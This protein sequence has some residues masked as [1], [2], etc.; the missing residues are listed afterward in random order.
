MNFWEHNVDLKS[1]NT[2]NL[3]AYAKDFFTIS[4]QDDFFRFYDVYKRKENN[5]YCR[6]IFV[7]GE[8]SNTI[9]VD[10]NINA[11]IVDVNTRGIDF[12]KENDS[13]VW[14][15]CKAG[16]LFRD[17][18]LQMCSNDYSGLENL[19]GIYGTVGA[20]PVQ[21]IGAYGCEVKDCIDS[22]RYFDMTCGEYRV[23]TAEECQFGYRDSIFKHQDGTK[24]ITD[25]VFKLNKNFVLNNSYDAVKK[26]FNNISLSSITP[27]LVAQKITEIRNKKLPNPKVLGNC[28][29]F[30]KNPVITEQQFIN[31]KAI[32]SDIVA[33]EDEKGWKLSAAWLISSCGF[34]NKKE[35]GL[36]MYD[37][38]PLVLVNYG[39]KNT[40]YLIDYIEQIKKVV[41]SQF[42]IDLIAEPHFVY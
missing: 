36:S 12:L 11:V 33:F 42:D 31:L 37:K 16:E 2:M 4:K 15:N 17:F 6:K 14:V 24:I 3:Y 35:N 29:S 1:R 30:F 38:Q 32:H 13:N 25:V 34:K 28:G 5:L 21:N 23:L 7:L 10:N 19:A 9:F 20:A 40:K 26:Q 8:G 41:K 22:V 39:I 18:V 27:L